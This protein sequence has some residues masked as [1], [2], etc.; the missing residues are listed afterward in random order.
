MNKTIGQAL[1]REKIRANNKIKQYEKFRDLD[2]ENNFLYAQLCGVCKLNK[3]S[4][5]CE[6]KDWN[7][8]IRTIIYKKR[9]YIQRRWSTT[10]GLSR[11]DGSPYLE[12][13]GAM[14]KIKEKSWLKRFINRIKNS[15]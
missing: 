3:G 8:E 1:V 5:Y 15:C 11:Y 13:G 10:L 7:K 12:D 4:C 2:A 9:G 6:D 14:I